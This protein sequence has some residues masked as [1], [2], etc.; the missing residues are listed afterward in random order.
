MDLTILDVR[1]PLFF[2]RWL[3]FSTHLLRFAKKSRK[4]IEYKFNFFAKCS[5]KSVH[6]ITL[7]SFATVSNSFENINAT[8]LLIQ[9]IIRLVCLCWRNLWYFDLKTI[10]TMRELLAPITI[11]SHFFPHALSLKRSRWSPIST[12]FLKQVKHYLSAADVKTNLSSRKF[13]RKHN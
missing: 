3:H 9:N 4:Y 8:H 11:K 12:L 7:F 10:E 5:S 1:W 2:F 13:S 6:L